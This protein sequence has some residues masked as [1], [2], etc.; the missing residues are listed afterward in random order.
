MDSN[1]QSNINTTS[2]GEEEEGNN[3][4]ALMKG[5]NRVSSIQNNLVSIDDIIINKP[6]HSFEIPVT[7][8]LANEK[9][10]YN[11]VI[12]SQA[13]I[14]TS[15]KKKRKRVSFAGTP[16]SDDKAILCSEQ[17]FI[18]PSDVFSTDSADEAK[19]VKM[20]PTHKKTPIPKR[21]LRERTNSNYYSNQSAQISE[22]LSSS[23]NESYNIFEDTTKFVKINNKGY[24]QLNILGR[25]GSSSVYRMISQ[26]DGQIY[27]YKV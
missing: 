18:I 16:L 19:K 3:A 17:K 25:G 11:S 12:P 14:C 10:V 27:A 1:S 15:T 23:Y 9:V 7:P 6:I 26:G 2:L 22:N 13:V 8:P 20:E 21:P 24:I 4:V 5:L